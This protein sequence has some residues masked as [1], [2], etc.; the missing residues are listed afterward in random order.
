[1]IQLYLD[2]N[3]LQCICEHI[4][5]TRAVWTF[6][7]KAIM[8]TRESKPEQYMSPKRYHWGCSNNFRFGQMP[9]TKYFTPMLYYWGSWRQLVV[10]ATFTTIHIGTVPEIL[11]PFL[12]N[13]SAGRGSSVGC[14]SAWYA[15]GRGFDPH[16]R[17]HS[18]A[19][20]FYGHSCPSAD[21]RRAV[22]SYWRKNVH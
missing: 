20:N 2:W 15:D 18:F 6:D 4:K 21:S 17:Q 8:L 13:R 1:M 14:A 19:E 16:V 22:V 3:D 9:V 7:K 11:E 5:E 10:I 12:H